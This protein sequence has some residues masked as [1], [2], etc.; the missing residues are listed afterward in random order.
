M[1]GVRQR[2]II[3]IVKLVDDGASMTAVCR[4]HARPYVCFGE[5]PGKLS[6]VVRSTALM[7]GSDYVQRTGKKA[8]ATG[9]ELVAVQGIGGLG[10]LANPVFQPAWL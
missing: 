4:I 5:H 3:I 2:P 8:G 1:P 7:R 10:H 9:G 6:S